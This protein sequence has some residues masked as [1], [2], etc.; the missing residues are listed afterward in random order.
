MG[1]ALSEAAK[2][3]GRTHPN[4]AVGAVVARGSRVLGLGH[5][6]RAGGPHAEI[7]AIRRAGKGARGADLYVTLEP[8]NHHGRTPPC[9]DAI[10]EAGIA[11]VFVGSI[12]PNPLVKGRGVQ[13]LR[14][15]G[16]AV[17]TG[18]L[19]EACDAANE[20]WFKF[21]TRKLPW[22]VLKAAVTLD[23]K[24]ATASGDSRWVSGPQSRAMAHALRDELD[25]ILVGVGTA[26]EDDPRLTARG[27]GQRDPVRVVVDST[28]RLPPDAR[29]LRQRS[30]APTLVACTLRAAP[31]RVKALER[32]G[33]EIV[34]CQSRD[35]KVDLKDLLERLAG[36]G[37]TSVLIE[38][39]AKIHGSFL[40]RSL[41]DEL[42][43]FIAPKLAGSDAP[44]WAGLAGPRRMGDAPFA[45]IVDSSRVGDDLLVTARPLR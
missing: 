38:G 25:A 20:M 15:A 19:R 30:P 43:L 12:D 4:P 29:L 7:E 31:A 39:G 37:L 42:Y 21:I 17:A 6:R 2:G 36:R 24:L 27:P 33:A 45:R 44:S 9:T 1:L 13:R 3:L 41:W 5:H 23:G 28:A 10:L 18:V 32:A 35:G 16:L 22:V 11:R 34:R 26:L 40:S 8:C 14:A